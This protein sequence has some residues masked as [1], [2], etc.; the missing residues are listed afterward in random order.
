MM[1]PAAQ[2]L[3]IFC[4]LQKAWESAQKLME[5]YNISLPEQPQAIQGPNQGPNQ[6]ERQKSNGKHLLR[7]PFQVHTPDQSS[8]PNPLLTSP[9][10]ASLLADHKQNMGSTPL[11]S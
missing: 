5:K 1:R 8:R 7:S 11:V 2:L 6:G 9:S 4:R 3:A 10:S